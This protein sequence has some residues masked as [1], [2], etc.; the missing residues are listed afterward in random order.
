MA[1]VPVT[2]VVPVRNESARL[3]DFLAAHAWARTIVVADNGSDDDSA[4]VAARHGAMVVPCPGMTIGAARNAG[5]DASRTEW[6]LALDI[7]ERADT[8]V[9][10]EICQV[11]AAPAYAAY[12]IRRRNFLHGREEVRGSLSRDWVVR[13]YQRP[14]RF[15]TPRVHERLEVAGATGALQA[16]LQ[17]WP[18]RDLSHQILKMDQYAR[19]GAE[20]LYASGIRATWVSLFLRPAW[21]FFKSYVIGGQILEGRTGLTAS[22]IGAQT[23]F[24]KYAHLLELERES[25]NAR[26]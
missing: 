13:L 22:L 10:E 2:I 21:R 4:L 23:A 8:S 25:R 6:I 9:A 19:W 20:E 3:P 14:L 5:A 24:L 18:Y 26:S 7:D 15:T 1:T 16:T 11:I 17:H 12:R